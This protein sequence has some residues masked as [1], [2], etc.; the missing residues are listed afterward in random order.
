MPRLPHPHRVLREP[1]ER[2]RIQS[3][4]HGGGTFA[5]NATIPA[6]VPQWPSG[7]RSVLTSGL[8]ASHL[9]AGGRRRRE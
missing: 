1:G 6:F 9:V 5:N 3:N 4:L 2:R 8:P 7:L